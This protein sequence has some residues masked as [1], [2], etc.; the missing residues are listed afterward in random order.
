M[1]IEFLI[2]TMNRDNLDFL[3][4]MFEGIGLE[5]INALIV[6]QCTAIDIPK[7]PITFSDK[8]RVLSVRG[9]GL[10]KSRNLL[11]KEATGDVCVIADDDLV[12]APDYLER[13]AA[14][15]SSKSI[16]ICAFYEK[17]RKLNS[18][19]VCE[20]T[21]HLM[22]VWSC[23]ISFRRSSIIDKGIYFDEQFGLGCGQ[24]EIG[25]ENIWL[26]DC[27][28]QN[29]KMIRYPYHA[30]SHPYPSSG[31]KVDFDTL[32]WRGPVFKRMFGTYGYYVLFR[33][34]L[35]MLPAYIRQENGFKVLYH[36][37]KLAWAY[38]P[39]K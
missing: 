6:N 28:K 26:A 22:S 12:Y 11:L 36:A 24:Y 25:E 1:Q 17:K 8:I 29:V 16:E 19:L 33:F 23:E 18:E 21:M 34:L 38:K 3:V 32:T 13:V 14:I 15:Y 4:P 31:L 35:G 30:V 2:S 20:K 27:L 5:R 10:A 37:V 39:E 7:N 9:T